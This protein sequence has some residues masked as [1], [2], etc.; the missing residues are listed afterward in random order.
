MVTTVV[1]RCTGIDP[2]I[3]LGGLIGSFI[4]CEHYYS[5]KIKDMKCGG[6]QTG[7][8]ACLVCKACPC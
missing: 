5:R 7:G 2:E 8:L 1:C 4:Y 3:N 6:W